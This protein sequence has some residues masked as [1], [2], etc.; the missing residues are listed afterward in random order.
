[1]A[2]AAAFRERG[3][4]LS[5]ATKPANGKLLKQA[6]GRSWPENISMPMSR[7]DICM[8]SFTLHILLMSLYLPLKAS[9]SDCKFCHK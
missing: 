7:R 6:C 4:V 3:E 9:L 1:M 8:I 5:V 2:G